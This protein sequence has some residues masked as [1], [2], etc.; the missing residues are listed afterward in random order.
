MG[1]HVWAAYVFTDVVGSTRLWAEHSEA[2]ERD[3]ARHDEIVRA[4]AVACGGVECSTAGD[5]FGLVFPDQSSAVSAAVAIQR[6]LAHETWTVPGGIRVRIGIHVGTAQSRSGG[7]YGPPLNEAA[8][9]MSVAHGGQIVV[10]GSVADVLPDEQVTDLGTHQLRDI[11][12][13]RHLF[14]IRADGLETGFPPLRSQRRQVSTLPAQRTTLIGRDV[15]VDRVRSVLDRHRLITV[16]GAGG[17]GKTRVA[18][19]AGGR[20]A[21]RFPS[22]VFFVDLAAV[23]DDAGVPGAFIDGIG[24]ARPPERS[25][26]DHLVVELAERHAL[27]VVDNCEHVV[28]AA[29]ELLD[30]LLAHAPLLHALATSREPLGLAGERVVD[31]LPL[32][33]DGPDSPAVQLFVERAV[34]AGCIGAFG[35][36][37]L[38]TV[39]EIVSR[40]DGVPLAIEL[41]AARART[42]SADHILSHLDDRFRLLTGRRGGDPRQ[43]TLET[44]IAWSY[45]LLE[46]DEQRALRTLALCAGPTS[47][48]T[49]ARLL[50]VDAPAASDRLGALAAKSLLVP[51]EDRG[52]VHGYRLLETIRA[53][54]RDRL[55]ELGD[56]D[57]A[58]LALEA[59]YSQASTKATMICSHSSTRKRTGQPAAFSRHPLAPPPPPRR[60]SMDVRTVPPS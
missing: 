2:M 14:Q 51:I 52:H 26:T 59:R 30:Q 18:I 10:S 36:A 17:V 13:D 32:E 27:L 6:A 57:R 60:C 4:L 24:R 55:L 9:I 50:G 49:A 1:E 45:D 56:L 48:T 21:E 47:L 29:A 44:A 7:W 33:A 46:P 15:D 42:M 54:G 39:V 5:S 3:L 22:G 37:E 38:D 20:A 28:D 53:F 35:R 23:T 40:L 8:R 43:R 25:A 58:R 12:G 16:V 34:D 41:A 19:E 31:L 11:D